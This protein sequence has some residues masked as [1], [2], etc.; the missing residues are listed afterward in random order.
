MIASGPRG[1]EV[2]ALLTVDE[3]GI[4]ATTT[5]TDNRRSDWTGT[6]MAGELV[7]R[8]NQDRR[9]LGLGALRVDPI[10]QR[11][12]SE[13]AKNMAK[14]GVVAHVLPGGAPPAKRLGEAGVRTK[15]FFENVAMARS[16]AQAHD[17]LWASPSHRM[18]LTDDLI[19]HVGVGVARTIGADGPVLYV[20]EHVAHR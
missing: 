9:T 13:H 10:L 19:T 11:T 6:G 3:N 17:E 14:M 5:R 4:A 15:R 16:V 8:I 2:V 20:V 7:G 12:A 18:A 1:A